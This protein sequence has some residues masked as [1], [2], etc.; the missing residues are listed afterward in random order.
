MSHVD[1]YNKGKIDSRELNR[2]MYDD[3]KAKLHNGP[4]N[5]WVYI[6]LVVALTVIGV[7][8]NNHISS[9]AAKSVACFNKYPVTE[10]MPQAEKEARWYLQDMCKEGK[11]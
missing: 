9:S 4:K 7:L 3:E 6:G 2:R 8:I 5:I 10:S 11:D 1:D